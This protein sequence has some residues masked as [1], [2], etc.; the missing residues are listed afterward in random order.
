MD[1]TYRCRAD[2]VEMDVKILPAKDIEKFEIFFAS[3]V[4]EAFRETWVPL[5]NTD[6]S[7][8]WIKL[9]NRKVV[10]RVFGV[11]RDKDARTLLDDGRWGQPVVKLRKTEARPFDKPI[12]VARNPDNGFALVFLCDPIVTTFLSGQYHGWDTAHDWCFGSD[13]VAGQPMTARARIIYR[14]FRD[15]QAM[16]RE[17]A[18]LWQDFCNLEDS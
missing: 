2:M 6:G 15:P 5:K 17:V 14:Q 4:V 16:P 10:G 1:L 9:D 7:P 12:L 8:D 11:V 18:Q 3:Y 13:L